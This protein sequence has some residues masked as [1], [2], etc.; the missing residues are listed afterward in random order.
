MA[1]KS[2]LLAPIGA[3][4][5]R[6]FFDASFTAECGC[7]PSLNFLHWK[8]LQFAFLTVFNVVSRCSYDYEI[9]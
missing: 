9:L 7:T 3:A 1:S 4:E 5:R 6:P 2:P 8:G